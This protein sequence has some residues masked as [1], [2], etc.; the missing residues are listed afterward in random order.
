M[1]R[2]TVATGMT[3]AAPLYKAVAMVDVALNTSMI[4]TTLLLMSYKLRSAG[5][6]EVKSFLCCAPINAILQME[7]E[8]QPP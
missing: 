3:A 1:Q 2:G 6:N 8:P 4:T 5:D 7:A